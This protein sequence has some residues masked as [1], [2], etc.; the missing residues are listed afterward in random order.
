MS[1][2]RNIYVPDNSVSAYK[3]ANYWSAIASRIYGFSQ[4][5]VDYPEYYAKYVNLI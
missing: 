4:L 1:S 3:S 5:A 2:T